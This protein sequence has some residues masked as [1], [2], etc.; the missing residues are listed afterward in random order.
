MNLEASAGRRSPNLSDNRPFR[1][2][3]KPAS[4]VSFLLLDGQGAI[5]S[6]RSQ[7]IYALNQTAAYIWCRFEEHADIDALCGELTRSGTP[8]GAARQYVRKIFESWLKLGL[9]EP[10][11]TWA[12]DHTRFP[13]QLTFNLDIAGFNAV[14]HSANAGLVELMSAFDQNRAA[15]RDGADTFHLGE[16]EGFV[17]VFHNERLVICCEP[18]ELVPL[19]KAYFT[20]QIL[21]AR[22]RDVAFHAA[23][24]VSKGRNLL[25]SGRPGAGKTTLALCLAARP[26]FDCAGDDIA[27]IAEN[28]CATA[29][30]FPFTVKA[31]AWNIANRF[32]ADLDGA[33]IH[34]RVDG[35]RVRYLKPETALGNPY[36]VGWIVFIRRKKGHAALEPLRPLEA[37][38]RVMESSYRAG[39]QLDIASCH[40]IKRMLEGARSFELR[41]SDLAEASDLMVRLC[42]E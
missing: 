17:E 7:Q 8:P 13:P 3:F 26:G 2:I 18:S 36:P 39:G 31:G 42:D 33:R 25:I 12:F 34:K 23:S 32:R 29:V 41:Y 21:A 24:V 22:S 20:E 28:G 37:M 15:V 40:A 10:N 35:K 38:G 14:V 27:L 30:P 5:F 4:G 11:H 19:I 6:E 9:V 1:G 16:V